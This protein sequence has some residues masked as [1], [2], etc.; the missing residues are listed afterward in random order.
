MKKSKYTITEIKL[1]NS[2]P[3]VK[4]VKYGRQIEYSPSFKKWAVIQSVKY[5]ELSANQIFEIA[6]FDIDMLGPRTAESRI[7]YWKGNLNKYKE[8]YYEPKDKLSTLE[9]DKQNNAILLLLLSRME[10]LIEIL[11]AKNGQR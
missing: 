6:G 5:P 1:L 7:R 10:E 11:G 9:L 3:N 8:L 4:S 2:N